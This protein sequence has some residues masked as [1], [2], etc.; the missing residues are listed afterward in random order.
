MV[1]HD[2]ATFPG[3]VLTCRII[4]ILEIEQTSKDKT[5]RNDR[6]F[7]VPRQSHAEQGLRH[8]RDLSRP[9]QQE[10]GRPGF[11]NMLKDA[12]RRKFDVLMVWSVDRLGRSLLDLIS[13]LQELH[14][15]SVD[16]FLQQ[17]AVDTTTPAGKAMYQ[18]LGVFAEF[19]RTVIQAR[20]NAGI[21][22]AKEQGT[23]TG[24]P[25][26]RPTIPADQEAVIRGH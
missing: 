25:F 12:T 16:L 21:A 6:L 11:D 10:L 24:R 26:G 22:R 14:G 17:Q 13:A 5:D 1:V 18:M 4:G 15:A 7:A 3:I 2:A 8:V 23:K 19:E 20:I 9:I